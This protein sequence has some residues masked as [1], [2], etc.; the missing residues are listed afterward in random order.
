MR[1]IGTTSTTRYTTEGST[2]Q[3]H[4]I[5]TIAARGIKSNEN[6]DGSWN[7]VNRFLRQAEPRGRLPTC[8]LK[9]NCDSIDKGGES[10]R[11]MRESDDRI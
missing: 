8:T 9:S 4:D 2:L 7:T 10:S 6:E 5:V 3:Q 1:P 11:K